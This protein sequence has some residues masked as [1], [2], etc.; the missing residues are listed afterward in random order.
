[1]LE[2]QSYDQ[3]KLVSKPWGWERWIQPGSAQFPFVLK[4]LKLLAGNRTS[5]QVHQQKSESIIILEG[6]GS[7]VLYKEKFDCEKY[8]QNQYSN[9]E[10]N[11]IRNN[12]YTEKLQPGTV[13]HTPPGTIHR[14]IALTDLTY[15]EAS[16]TELDDVIRLQDDNNRK[17]GKIESEHQ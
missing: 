10:L 13:I 17:H 6:T 9:E 1:M 15:I 5:L 3:I 7:I 11:F 14:M 12:L 16:T 4:Q 8:L 2:I